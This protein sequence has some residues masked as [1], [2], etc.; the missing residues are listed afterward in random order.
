MIC[1]SLIPIPG[2]SKEI[3]EWMMDVWGAGKTKTPS[4]KN[5]TAPQLED[6]GVQ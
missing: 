6:A 4:F 5:Q 3:A 1:Y 2:S